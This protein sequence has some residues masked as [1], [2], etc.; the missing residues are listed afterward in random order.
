MGGRRF[1]SRNKALPA[2]VE[3][4]AADPP[5]CFDKPIWRLF[6]IDCYRGTL[7]DPASRARISRGERPDYCT[8]CQQGYQQ[9]M[10]ARALC[11]PP[12][13]P[14]TMR[15]NKMIANKQDLT[16]AYQAARKTMEHEAAIE[17]VAARHGQDAETIVAVLEEEAA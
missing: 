13:N 14:E 10:Q 1:D 11:R 16:V 3:T 6:L 15:E 17:H 2:C 8:D 5:A 12:V 4:L 7:N 9:R